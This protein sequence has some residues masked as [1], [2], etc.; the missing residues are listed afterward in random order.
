L[1]CGLEKGL[2]RM[3]DKILDIDHGVKGGFA[4]A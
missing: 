4:A 3:D 1:S 2:D